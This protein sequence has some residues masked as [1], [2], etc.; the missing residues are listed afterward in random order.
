ML[1]SAFP[2]ACA[3]SVVA[4]LKRSQPRV[5]GD[6]CFPLCS[7]AVGAGEDPEDAVEPGGEADA[8][9][10]HGAPARRGVARHRAGAARA[11]APARRRRQQRPA[12]QGRQPPTGERRRRHVRLL[13]LQWQR[14]QRQPLKLLLGWKKLLCPT[15]VIGMICRERSW[16]GPWCKGCLK[17]V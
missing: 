1:I 2:F 15:P 6:T 12:A 4:T 17:R 13:P 16:L 7:L 9:D 5:G 8:A 11:A 14:R 10:E 3:R